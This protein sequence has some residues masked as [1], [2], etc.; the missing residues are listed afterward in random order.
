MVGKDANAIVLFIIKDLSKVALE[1]HIYIPQ[2]INHFYFLHFRFDY[3]TPPP[4][5]F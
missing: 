1:H 5:W 4:K 2:M 3:P